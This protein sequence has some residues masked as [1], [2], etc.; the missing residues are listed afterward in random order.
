MHCLPR[1]ATGTHMTHARFMSSYD[2]PYS[3][4]SASSAN[5]T[6]HAQ[7]AR[8]R[9]LKAQIKKE[10]ENSGVSASATRGKAATCSRRAIDSGS[11]I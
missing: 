5:A 10:K 6:R 2:D 7:E 11:Y 1:A 8:I 3:S 9:Q 4:P